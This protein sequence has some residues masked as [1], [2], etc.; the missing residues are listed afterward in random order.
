MKTCIIPAAFAAALAISG[1]ALAQQQQPQPQPQ[2]PQQPLTEE[3]RRQQA[4]VQALNTYANILFGQEIE[5]R[6]GHLDGEQRAAF[7]D[8]I[9][10]VDQFMQERLPQETVDAVKQRATTA[11]ADNQAN[12]CGAESENFVT[13][14][15]AMVAQISE[16]IANQA[17]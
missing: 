4:K 6:C 8:N 5:N 9:E 17:N 16:N 3:Q 13:Q 7:N 12:P 2:Q 10:T 1:A 11:G 15:A 14:V